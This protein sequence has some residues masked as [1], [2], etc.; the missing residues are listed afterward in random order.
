MPKKIDNRSG[1][2]LI[3]LTVTMMLVGITAAVVVPK[4]SGAVTTTRLN[5]TAMQMVADFETARRYA[6]STSTSQEIQVV[7]ANNEYILKDMP[8]MNH[9][10]VASY[11]VDLNELQG[12]VS[13]LSVDFNSTD[14]MTFDMYGKPNHGGTVVIQSGTQIR[15]ITIDASTGKVTSI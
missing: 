15:T 3:E 13:I 11:T 14:S 2:S 12:T 7:T 4:I 10:N 8:D 1:F 9:P 6:I 5:A